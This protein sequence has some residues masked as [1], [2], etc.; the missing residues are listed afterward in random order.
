MLRL[1]LL[2]SIRCAYFLV[3]PYAKVDCIFGG[4]EITR[5]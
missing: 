3:P 4:K 1:I 5:I 2:Y